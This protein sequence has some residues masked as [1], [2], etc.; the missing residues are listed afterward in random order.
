MTGITELEY[1]NSLNP[2]I[3]ARRFYNKVVEL[4]RNNNIE[5]LRIFI[6]DIRQIN[7]DMA[8]LAENISRNIIAR[9]SRH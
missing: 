3:M 1:N 2:E 9:A 5:G 4:T 8:V 7:N 6:A